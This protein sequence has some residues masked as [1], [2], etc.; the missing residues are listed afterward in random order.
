MENLVDAQQSPGFD[1]NREYS[2]PWLRASTGSPGTRRSPAA[3][4]Q[5]Q[6]LF[7]DPKLKGKVTMLMEMADSVGLVLLD[8]GDDPANVTDET[9]DRAIAKIQPP[10]TRA[11]SCRFTG[12]DYAPPLAE[13]RLR[14]LRRV[15]GRPRPAHPGEPE[16][17]VGDP[18]E[19]RDHLDRQHVHPARGQ[20]ADR[21]DLH[22]LRLRPDDRGPDRARH[23]LHHPRQGAKEA[24][25]KLDPN[26]ASNQLVFPTDAM[27]AKL[28]PNDPKMVS[29][30]D[31]ITTWQAVIGQ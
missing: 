20:R 16:S 27:L 8:N 5:H 13:G 14:R 9:F 6:Q 31:Y 19:G 17:Q 29:N 23:E 11:R 15:V 1:P 4:D 10:S 21:V 26:A 2:F 30:A 7:T 3:R 22:E 12:N 25:R 18:G 28:H 24:A